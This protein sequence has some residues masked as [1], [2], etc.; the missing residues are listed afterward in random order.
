VRDRAYDQ[1]SDEDLLMETASCCTA[2]SAWLSAARSS[3][4]SSSINA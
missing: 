1:E 4:D 2:T 3:T